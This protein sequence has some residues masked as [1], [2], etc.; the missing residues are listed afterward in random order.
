MRGNVLDLGVQI[1]G[2][3]FTHRES[4]NQVVGQRLKNSRRHEV[5]QYVTRARVTVILMIRP[6]LKVPFLFRISHF[7]WQA[8]W[9]FLW[10]RW[11]QVVNNA[12]LLDHFSRILSIYYC[13]IRSVHPSLDWTPSL[14]PPL[15]KEPDE[16]FPRLQHRGSWL[17]GHQE[18]IFVQRHSSNFRHESIALRDWSDNR[19]I[20][21]WRIQQI[22]E[23]HLT[24]RETNGLLVWLDFIVWLPVSM[25][26]E[27]PGGLIII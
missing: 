9:A 14:I 24:C 21:Q 27:S 26:P 4:T 22:R 3:L 18:N 15:I 11:V 16:G 10:A 20:V 19:S 6:C 8:W 13:E 17:T 2:N 25:E 12:L 23:H 7:V 5:R 1:V